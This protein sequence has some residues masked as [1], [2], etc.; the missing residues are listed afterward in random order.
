M[1]NFKKF[2]YILYLSL[3]LPFVASAFDSFDCLGTKPDWNFSLTENKF[4]FKQNT[5]LN[6][7]TPAVPPEAAVNMDLEHI[8]VFRTKVRNDDVIIIIQKQSCSDGKS[9]EMFSYEGLIIMKDKVFHGCCSKK[10]L[11]T[12]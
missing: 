4:I 9:E 3:Y 7:T 6:F 5:T 2:S 11:L 8:R 10:L 12:H 1:T